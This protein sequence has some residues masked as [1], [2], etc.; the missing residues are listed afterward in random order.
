MPFEMQWI[1][2][3][4]QWSVVSDQWLVVSDQ[5]LVVSDQWLVVS[6][7][8]V[9]R[10]LYRKGYFSF[11]ALHVNL[12][13]VPVIKPPSTSREAPVIHSASSEARNTAARP[14]SFGLPKRG[15]AVF[16]A[17]ASIISWVR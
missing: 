6:K 3:S 5:W 14:T 7:K 10:L 11:I 12:A 4:G 17:T 13:Y 1:V 8:L 15:K 2:V 16:S 9:D